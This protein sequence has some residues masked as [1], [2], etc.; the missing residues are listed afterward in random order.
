MA[1]RAVAVALSEAGC[2]E[3]SRLNQMLALLLW[4]PST[5]RYEAWSIRR[6]G[7]RW[8]P[9]AVARPVAAGSWEALVGHSLVYLGSATLLAL[10]P[11]TGAYQ[12]RFL[13]RG[14]LQYD[15]SV[16]QRACV[17]QYFVVLGIATACLSTALG[18]MFGS[19]R[20]MQ[21]LARDRIYPILAPLGAG[22]GG[23]L[24]PSLGGHRGGAGQH[25][26]AGY[27]EQRALELTLTRLY[28]R[29]RTGVCACLRL[30]PLQLPAPHLC[31]QTD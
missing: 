13:D 8:L 10:H 31:R 6:S 21:A 17:N 12:V 11:T 5:G 25:G 7:R 15:L 19:A 23:D 29:C 18:S 26:Q 3:L 24:T 4:E 28:R 20:I 22:V 30:R 16:M 1:V 14:A 9:S 2:L 27:I